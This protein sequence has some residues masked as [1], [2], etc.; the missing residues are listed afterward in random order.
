ME[1]GT[2]DLLKNARRLK[3]ELEAFGRSARAFV[4]ARPAKPEDE[5][6]ALKDDVLGT[7]ECLLTDDLQPAL[8]KL[9][10]LDGLLERVS[11]LERS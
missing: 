9:E 3:K 10:E 8:R 7:V 1:K 11:S 2:E 6:E 5:L 4:R